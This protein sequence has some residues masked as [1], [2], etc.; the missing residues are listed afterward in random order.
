M[1]VVADGRWFML[2]MRLLGAEEV[3]ASD[4]RLVEELLRQPKRFALL[5]YLVAAEP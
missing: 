1:S 5:A 2:A 3:W 4:G